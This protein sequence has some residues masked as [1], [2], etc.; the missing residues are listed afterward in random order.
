ML[1]IVVLNFHFRGPKKQRVPKWMRK[2]IIGYLGRIF[3][4]GYES[5]Q[6]IVREKQEQELLESEKR[7]EAAE[8][9]L[10]SSSHANEN[11]FKSRFSLF[12]RS[13]QR[14]KKEKS[15]IDDDSLSQPN[16]EYQYDN[17]HTEPAYL[18][19]N[20]RLNLT[21]ITAENNEYN[22]KE[23]RI[24]SEYSNN[25][26]SFNSVIHKTNKLS[27]TSNA[28]HA[29]EARSSTHSLSESTK[30]KKTENQ[31]ATGSGEQQPFSD[32]ISRNLE[33]ILMKMQKSFDPFKLQDENLKLAILKEI[34]E[35]QRLLLS[36]SLAKKEDKHLN[37]TEIYDE[38]KILAMIVDRIC[39]FLYLA[40]L[41]VST[42]LFFLREQVYN[43]L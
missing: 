3:C 33:K 14:E 31:L 4:F 20:N 1:T 43:D 24:V 23:N 19:T 13:F 41:F 11:L 35:C 27:K 36:S 16:E 26:S 32:E 7:R 9:M 30:S 21:K 12:K 22:L 38:W 10:S 8:K 18:K 39:F 40:A 34:L 5:K 15:P 37:I 2:Y 6:F 25:T 28:A 42:G 29:N 17:P